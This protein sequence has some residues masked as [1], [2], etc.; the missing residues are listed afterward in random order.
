MTAQT[1]PFQPTREALDK[2]I[3]RI[4][5]SVPKDKGEAGLYARRQRLLAHQ[6]RIAELAALEHAPEHDFYLARIKME[7]GRYDEALLLWDKTLP[8]HTSSHHKLI[9][10]HAAV[11][12]RFL[13]SYGNARMK[14]NAAKRQ[15][16]EQRRYDKELAALTEIENLYLSH[17]LGAAFFDAARAGEGPAPKLDHIAAALELGDYTPEQRRSVTGICEAVA[18]AAPTAEPEEPP[19]PEGRLRRLLSRPPAPEPAP[20]PVV[21]GGSQVFFA[22]F[23]WTGSGALFDYYKQCASASEPFGPAEIT[24][25]R[26]AEFRT[27]ARS[28][29]PA[30]VWEALTTSIERDVIGFS[31]S[32]GGNPRSCAS[33]ALVQ[34]VGTDEAIGR[35]LAAAVADLAAAYREGAVREGFGRFL[36]AVANLPDREPRVSVFSNGINAKLVDRIDHFPNGKIVVV[37]RDMRDVYASRMVEADRLALPADRFI[38]HYSRAVEAFDAAV[39]KLAHPERVVTARFEDFVTSEDYRRELGAELGLDTATV[40]E[41][42][43]AYRPADSLGNVGVHRLRDDRDELE[44]IGRAFP[45][46]LWDSTVPA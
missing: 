37:T 7:L 2:E 28:G 4:Y 3:G 17:R 19:R 43:G 8:D 32:T 31:G 23:G 40:V 16:L 38:G 25:F 9:H 20:A 22:G 26:S 15:G 39:A 6:D 36:T 30:E 41:R 34:A 29:D 33:K 27:I 12:Y 18:A 35:R 14:L 46:S 5:G 44:R 10:Y 45:E 21:E 11:C 42:E 13:G 24:F 1:D